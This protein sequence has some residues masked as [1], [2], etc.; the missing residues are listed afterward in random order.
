MYR[1]CK[2]DR[3]ITQSIIDRAFDT[4]IWIFRESRIWNNLD[5][6]QQRSAFFTFSSSSISLATDLASSESEIF[7]AV[8]DEDSKFGLFRAG[9]DEDLAELM[10]LSEA[11]DPERSAIVDGLLCLRLSL[12]FDDLSAKTRLRFDVSP[13]STA[14]SLD[15]SLSFSFSGPFTQQIFNINTNASHLETALL[16]SQSHTCQ[17]S[18]SRI[19]HET[20]RIRGDVTISW[21]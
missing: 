3:S 7:L 12:A 9:L 16:L 4:M 19:G 2:I 13:S 14:V 10:D 11:F 6:T 21:Q 8:L 15:V 17:V 18:R 5:L 20:H 1:L